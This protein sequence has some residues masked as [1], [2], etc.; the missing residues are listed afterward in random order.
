MSIQVKDL[1]KILS[2]PKELKLHMNKKNNNLLSPKNK[3]ETKLKCHLKLK[4]SPY[5]MLKFIFLFKI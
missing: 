1:I 5:L 3:Q 2:A 4:L